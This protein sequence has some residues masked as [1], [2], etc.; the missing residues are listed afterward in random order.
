MSRK[1]GTI[2][3]NTVISVGL[4]C[5]NCGNVYDGQK[6]PNWKFCPECDKVTELQRIKFE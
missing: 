6:F 2:N 1:I 4:Y 5:P 3:P